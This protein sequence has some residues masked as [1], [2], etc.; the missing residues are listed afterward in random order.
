[1]NYIGKNLIRVDGHDKVTGRTLYTDDIDIPDCWHVHILRSPVARGQLKSIKLDP[2]Y[3][4]SSVCV[5]TAA[6]IPGPNIFVMHD[7]S[8]PVLVENEI[9]YRGEPIALIAAETLDQ[10]REAAT[11]ITLDIDEQSPLLH[12]TEIVDLFKTNNPS[13]VRLSEQTIKKGNL[14][15]GF[16]EADIIVEGEYTAGRQEQL[17]I[18]PQGMIAT[19]DSD[20]GISIQGSMQC[21]YYIVNEAHE[22][23]NLPK[24]N[25]RIKQIAVGGAFG[26]KEE[27]PSLMAAYCALPALKSGHP[28]KL[29][30]DREQDMRYTTKRHP[31]WTRYKTGLKNDGTIT[32]IQVDYLLDGGAYL[33]LSDVVMYRGVLHAALGYR[34]D[35][36]H[37]NGLVAQ[38]NTFPS[39]AFRGFG[40]PQA[41]WGFESH[42]D[43]MAAACNMTP[44]EF[45]LK[46]CLIKGDITP[47]G[48]ILKDSVGSPD[49]LKKALEKSNFSKKWNN[50]SRGNP[51]AKIWQGIGLSFFAHGAGFTGDGEARIK[52]KVD[53]EL[54]KVSVVKGGSQS[55]VTASSS[56]HPSNFILQ[57]SPSLKSEISHP[58]PRIAYPVFHSVTIRVSSTEMGQ[59]AHTVLSQMVAEALSIDI[60]RVQYPNADTTQVP[61]SGPTVASR[62]TMVV[63]STLYNAALKLK[64]TLESFASKSCFNGQQTTLSND[65]FTTQTGDTKSFDEVTALYL[66]DKN[67]SPRIQH[68]FDLPSDI[69]WNQQT[70]EGDAYPAYSWGCNIAEVEVDPL[71]LE[72]KVKKVTA[73]FDIG[74]VI[75]PILAEGQLE[76]GLTQAL[77]YTLLERIAIK[78][79]LPDADRMQT[80]IVPTSMD[81]PEFDITFVEYPYDFAQPGAKGVGEIPM[82]GL[83]PA[84]ANAIESATNIRITDLPITPEKLHQQ[85]YQEQ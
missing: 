10:A 50:S 38:T 34:C 79:G 78:D 39:G 4:W 41:Y 61:D 74:R 40:A 37:V 57:T 45:R 24:E 11:H 85:L 72:I 77:G 43:K 81:T 28:A 26:G 48:Q 49:V 55:S 18:E 59:G 14:E 75:N 47:T 22:A 84:I 51:N 44:H 56:L 25:V 5:V 82:D 36:V 54:S 63:G 73:C 33:T 32:A 23:L 58:E 21:P 83:A 68:G 53:L 52:S 16:A 46:N 69:Q 2:D 80:Y 13:L 1:M 7:R 19:P 17:Y 20:G 12:L 70:F 30:Y 8:M 35:N 15:K 67:N 29:I 64:Q 76:G 9:L 27:F 65:T 62:T 3:N 6:D 42:I 31:V 66:T 71:T 60:R